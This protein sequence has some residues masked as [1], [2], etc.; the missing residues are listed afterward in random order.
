MNPNTAAEN[1]ARPNR[2]EAG[3]TLIE[4]LVAMAIFSIG[5][6]AVASMQVAAVNG[7][8]T[9]RYNNE[10]SVLAQDQLE[11]L[12]LMN[13]DPLS[14]PT[15]LTPGTSHT[16]MDPTGQYRISWTIPNLLP[17][18]NAVTIN[19]TVQWFERDR[20]RRISYRFVKA[21]SI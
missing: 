3:Y 13:Y 20:L 12:I 2:K 7:N 21:Q 15:E 1:K 8:A 6:L 18:S 4:I 17:T 14:P 9:A 10:A 16:V 5:I 19:M 11:R